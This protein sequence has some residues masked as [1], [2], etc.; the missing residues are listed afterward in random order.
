MIHLELVFV[1]VVGSMSSFIL[2]ALWMSSFS[3]IICRE[4]YI[5]FIVLL[6]FL[7]QRSVDH[8]YMSLFLGS[9]FCFIFYFCVAFADVCTFCSK[10]LCA[11]CGSHGTGKGSTHL[12][13]CK[14]PSSFGIKTSAWVAAEH[15]LPNTHLLEMK[16]FQS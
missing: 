10:K 3:N 11:L 13:V 14:L 12:A 7:C 1:E 15:P 8:I 2:F 5:F 4:D 6:M 16:R 9:L